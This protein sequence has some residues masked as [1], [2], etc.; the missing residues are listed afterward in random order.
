MDMSGIP[1]RIVLF[2]LVAVSAVTE[3]VWRRASLS[4][5]GR[6]ADPAA[7]SRRA[8]ESRPGARGGPC[9]ARTRDRLDV[10]FRRS[11]AQRRT[12]PPASTRYPA[13]VAV[14]VNGDGPVLTLV[15][16]EA[17][18]IL[19]ADAQP[20][21]RAG[22]TVMLEGERDMRVTG[23]AGGAEE[24]VRLAGVLRPDVV[25]LDLDLPGLGGLEAARRIR[26]DP[27]S[28]DVR[29]VILAEHDSGEDVLAAL[30]AGALAFVLK[31]ADPAEL[32]RAVRVVAGGEA[33]LSPS[34]TRILIAAFSSQSRP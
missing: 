25:L 6:G 12:P 28:M 5:P 31:S 33:L 16:S 26:D 9:G 13:P 34:A 24:A 23:A 14:G 3:H 29:V 21:V 17:I 11:D 30:R 7:A 18:R 1:T 32:V 19:I 4:H 20:V 27:G 2:G 10:P 8:P 22:F 15:E